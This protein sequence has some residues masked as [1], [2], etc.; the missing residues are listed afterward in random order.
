MSRDQTEDAK[1]LI[2]AAAAVKLGRPLDKE[3]RKRLYSHYAEWIREIAIQLREAKWP[4]APP[5]T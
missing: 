2:A 1:C 5:E 3:E 4:D